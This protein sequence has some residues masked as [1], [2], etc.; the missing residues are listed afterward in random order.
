MQHN[1]EKR[2]GLVTTATLLCMW[3]CWLM[4]HYY[5]KPFS[6]PMNWLQ[7]ASQLKE[8]FHEDPFPIIYPTYLYLWLKYTG[9]VFVFFANWP[10]IPILGGVLALYTRELA[11]RQDTA[12]AP[13]LIPS[14][15]IFTLALFFSFDIPLLTYLSNPYRDPLAHIFLFASASLL[16]Y[17]TRKGARHAS[18][19]LLLSGIL[20][21]LSYATRETALV[22]LPA[23]FLTALYTTK[24]AT[25]ATRLRLAAV[26]LCGLLPGALPYLIQT[27]HITG[28][29]ILP[30]KTAT[31]SATIAMPGFI[32]NRWSDNL[33]AA[34]LYCAHTFSPFFIIGLIM[35]TIEC[36]RTR[37]PILLIGSALPAVLYLILYLLYHSF[38]PRYFWIVPLFLIPYAALGLARVSARMAEKANPGSTWAR[39]ALPAALAIGILAIAMV[40]QTDDTN[41]GLKL[42]DTLDVQREAITKLE[43]YDLILAERPLR[44]IAR[45]FSA[46]HAETTW[47]LTETRSIQIPVIHRAIEARLERGETLAVIGSAPLNEPDRTRSVVAQGFLLTPRC[48][49]F[50]NST[51]SLC[52]DKFPT[53]FLYELSRYPSNTPPTPTSTTYPTPCIVRTQILRPHSTT[54]TTLPTFAISETHQA[55]KQ[56]EHSYPSGT[57][58]EGILVTSTPGTSFYPIHVRP[59]DWPSDYQLLSGDIT[60]GTK[61]DPGKV[62]LSGR[63]RLHYSNPWGTKAR[64]LVCR[65]E[66]RVVSAPPDAE[67]AIY[68][69]D[70]TEIFRT[71][72]ETSA[73]CWESHTVR[74]PVIPQLPHYIDLAI[75]TPSNSSAASIALD[76]VVLGIMPD[77]MNYT[78]G[79]SEDFPILRSGFHGPEWFSQDE[80]GRW[81]MPEASLEL[82]TPTTSGPSPPHS[83]CITFL[84]LR[85]DATELTGALVLNGTL[86]PLLKRETDAYGAITQRHQIP[87]STWTEQRNILNISCPAWS[88]S[89]AGTSSDHRQLGI[90]L[91]RIWFE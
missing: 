78:L 47:L 59:D 64:V 69:T 30:A 82:L 35:Q 76:G 4:L 17:G 88:P 34:V 27:Y 18:G 29:F 38:V 83:L 6:D 87:A 68:H 31:T 14:S 42:R 37:K 55:T 25:M 44:E 53:P 24:H 74:F 72:L 67:L 77:S 75:V 39:N 33:L 23:L 57:P 22:A 5:I 65:L 43:T 81:T 85:P 50:G 1:R 49:I 70:G 12:D 19:S 90:P 48:P 2:W 10:L 62:L 15:A 7:F 32:P 45:W 86:L 13:S 54:E 16:I 8:T 52:E 89:L 66:T 28:Q 63:A 46:A 36:V 21:G 3:F 91:C 40:T 61:S 80:K 56:P 26:F 58:T 79:S 73:E 41:R 20:F 60:Y 71:Q 51:S 84:P 9:P 11:R